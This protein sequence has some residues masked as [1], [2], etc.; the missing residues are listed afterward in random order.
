MRRTPSIRGAARERGMVLIVVLVVLMVLMVGGMGAM[1]AADT[2][3]VLSGNFS[4]QQA[5]AQASD[6]A[7]T[8]ALSV[9][10]G[11]VAGGGGNTAVPNQYM[12]VMATT[13]NLDSLGIPTSITWSSVPCVDEKGA[14]ISDCT[15]DTGNYRVQYMVER[16]C[17]SSPTLSDVADIRAKCEY[18]AISTSDAA[19]SIGVHYRVLIRVRG[20]RGT[21]NWYEA[22]VSGPAST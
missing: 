8:D 7:I 4:F 15:A 2:G 11:R 20:P 12:P 16:L 22:V 10:A 19:T 6:R 14:G 5:S 1:R 18:D 13:A 21:L 17:S 9:I 3:N